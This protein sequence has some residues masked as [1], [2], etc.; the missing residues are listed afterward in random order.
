M[1]K[2]F[3]E[4]EEFPYLLEDISSAAKENLCILLA[5]LALWSQY[6]K[7]PITFDQMYNGCSLDLHPIATT[8]DL[9]GPVWTRLYAGTETPVELDHYM[10][11]ALGPMLTGAIS[12]MGVISRKQVKYNAEAKDRMATLQASDKADAAM[13]RGAYGP[14]L[15]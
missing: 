15:Y 2:T 5:N 12:K 7:A 6:G 10:P 4:P 3:W 1:R 13:D 11:A 14:P 9:L 8:R